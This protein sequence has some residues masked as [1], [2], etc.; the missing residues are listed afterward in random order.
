[1]VTRGTRVVTSV[2][3]TGITTCRLRC[4]VSGM[5][6][7]VSGMLTHVSGMG[8]VVSKMRTIFK[9]AKKS[10]DKICFILFQAHTFASTKNNYCVTI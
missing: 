10:T 5:L 7:H 4:K 1:M 9:K 8:T 2:L 6:T 3:E